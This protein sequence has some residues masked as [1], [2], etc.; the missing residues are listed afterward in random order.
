MRHQLALAVLVLLAGCTADPS[1]APAERPDV[2]GNGSGEGPS[3][4]GLPMNATVPLV[5]MRLT[6]CDGWKAGMDWI[7][8]GPPSPNPPE[9]QREDTTTGS[10]VVMQAWE[11]SRVN[12]GPFERGP[13]HMVMEYT[14]N[15]SAPENCTLADY[16][17]V[18]WSLLAWYVN[19]PEI[20]SYLSQLGIPAFQITANR[21]DVELGQ[22]ASHEWRWDAGSGES[23]VTT[24]DAG[25]TA[26]TSRLPERFFWAN[27][28]A[29]SAFEILYAGLDTFLGAQLSEGTLS[30]PMALARNAPV[31]ASRGQWYPSIDADAKHLTW[32]DVTCA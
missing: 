13:I 14:D 32:Q 4:P 23:R 17:V 18:A 5:G 30:D 6:D 7:G 28:T 8:P 1:E 15:F 26:P 25:G 22:G 20:V 2:T 9:W 27:G 3:Q 21:N 12:I 16:T 10:S 11:C 24:Y 29:V 19:D 31:F